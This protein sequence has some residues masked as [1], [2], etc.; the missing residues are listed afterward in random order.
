MSPSKER[1]DYRC[2]SPSS[3]HLWNT[4]RVPLLGYKIIFNLE[5]LV[6]HWIKSV[7]HLVFS[8][9]V[10]FVNLHSFANMYFHPFSVKI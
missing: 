4:Y 8:E 1:K 9:L 3:K 2:F 5:A 7:E 10:I 6:S